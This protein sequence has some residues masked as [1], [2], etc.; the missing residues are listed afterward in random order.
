MAANCPNTKLVLGGDSQGAMVIDLITIARAPV[1]GALSL[2]RYRR[3]WLIT[4]LRSLSSGIRR[5]DISAAH[6]RD[7]PVLW[8]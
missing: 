2:R 5:P 6:E 3:T 1:A 4:L 7:Q 8:G